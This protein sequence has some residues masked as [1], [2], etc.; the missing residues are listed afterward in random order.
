MG[1]KSVG[2]VLRNP[3]L[4]PSSRFVVVAVVGRG[5]TQSAN[6]LSTKWEGGTLNT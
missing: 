5:G 6:C 3:R 4:G 2:E 1:Q